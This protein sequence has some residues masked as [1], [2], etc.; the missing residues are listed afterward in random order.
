MRRWLGVLTVLGAMPAGASAQGVLERL[1]GTWLGTGELLGRPAAFELTWAP[2]LGGRFVRLEL[3]NFFVSDTGRTPVLEAVGYYP[4]AGSGTGTWVD[5][6]GVVFT[7]DVRT[8]G[9]TLRVGWKGLRESG[10]SEY[11]QTSD[12][13]LVVTD[14]VRQGGE[15]RVFA[16][17]TLKR[18]ATSP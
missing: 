11:V 14:R 12:S 8:S 6:R 3:E 7:L 5:S 13:V 15:L 10:E 1:E 16:T 2:A 18:R 17:S 9:D 4:A